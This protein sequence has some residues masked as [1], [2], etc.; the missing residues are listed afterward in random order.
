MPPHEN[1]VD[2]L[3]LRSLDALDVADVLRV[4]AE[5]ERWAA[6]AESGRPRQYDAADAT[7]SVR[8]SIDGRGR[9]EDLHVSPAWRERLSPAEFAAAVHGAY[10]DAMRMAIAGARRGGE[11]QPR[12]AA[13]P[14]PHDD[15]AWYVGRDVAD[16]EWV[17]STWDALDGVGAELRRLTQ[18]EAQGKAQAD[19][20]TT[21]SS[22]QGYLTVHLRGAGLVGILGAVGRISGADAATLRREAIAVLQ[23]A[24][25]ACECRGG[26]G[27]SDV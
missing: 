15:H 17:Q 10:T 9:V 5:V 7:G 24:R 12:G 22:P 23:A 13:Q 6:V 25:V 20:D 8:V 26:G 4:Q 18:L 2:R 1:H 19:R 14:R 27:P 3:T 16:R 21:I 11:D